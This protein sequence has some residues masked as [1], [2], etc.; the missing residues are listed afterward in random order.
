MTKY[1]E[2]GDLLLQNETGRNMCRTQVTYR[3]AS[4]NS[5]SQCLLQLVRFSN[6]SLRNGDQGNKRLKR[7][8]LG[9]S[10]G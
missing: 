6:P 5:P 3:G 1:E 4:W 8:D 7:E 10:T 9:H 2:E